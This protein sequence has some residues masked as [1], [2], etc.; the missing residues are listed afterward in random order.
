MSLP[1]EAASALGIGS[2]D[3]KLRAFGEMKTEAAGGIKVP[4]LR[5]ERPTSTM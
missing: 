3:K 4:V 2:K 5:R 1:Q